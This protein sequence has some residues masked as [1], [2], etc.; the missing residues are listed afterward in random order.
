MIAAL[1]CVSLVTVAQDDGAEAYEWYL[2]EVVNDVFI[3]RFDFDYYYQVGKAE[4][5]QQRAKG[6]VA[7]FLNTPVGLN[8]Q[9]ARDLV[10]RVMSTYDDI[11]AVGS[12]HMTSDT[13]WK[14][15]R[16]DKNKF[17]FSVKR[18]A[19][20]NGTYYVSVTETAGYYKSLGKGKK[21]DSQA[22]KE[23][24][25]QDSKPDRRSTRRSR[26][27]VVD[28]DEQASAR[29]DNLAPQ[30]NE[31]EEMD[32]APVMSEKQRRQ[33]E[34][35]QKEAA[36]MAERARS[37]RAREK[38]QEEA[39]ALKEAEKQRKAEE[40]KKKEEEKRLKKEAEKRQRE[41]ERQAREQAQREEAEARKRAA[42]PKPV[43][44][45]YHYSDVALW[46]SEK[47]D[48]TQTA[49]DD[50]SC[51]MFSTA[52][53]DVE[54][55]KLAIKNALKGSNARMA[56]PWRVNNETHAIETGYTVDG[57]VLVFAIGNDDAG[58]VTLTVTEVSA[59]EFEAFK[60]GLK[61]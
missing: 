1:A 4:M 33:Q 30:D 55:A 47:Y 32:E 24:K 29:E 46:L 17:R 42:A 56:I 14:E 58:Q 36:E 57:H 54:M 8:S 52:V 61:P 5:Q 19:L 44:S 15:Y 9:K 18:K 21:D 45:R 60:Q 13:Y 25:K 40:K 53:K 39:R 3:K 59:E 37:R 48:F 22:V 16:Y 50:S 41:E 7:Y 10:D 12:W 23:E 28:P 34:R 20:D 26:R 6:E 27:Q 35:E 51:T 38:Q 2:D 43:E 11:K 49:G 31:D